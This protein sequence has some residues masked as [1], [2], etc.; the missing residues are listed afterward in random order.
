M[1]LSKSSPNTCVGKDCGLFTLEESRH[2]LCFCLLRCDLFDLGVVL[3]NLLRVICMD[4]C[5]HRIGIQCIYI[6]I[7]YMSYIY[8]YTRVMC[9]HPT[10]DVYASYS[11][12]PCIGKPI[13]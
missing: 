12:N 5:M 3:L 4:S 9:T 1:C 6:Y 13:S 7:L 2:L 8:I 11:T 10:C